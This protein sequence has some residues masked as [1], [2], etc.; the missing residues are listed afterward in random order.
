M[1]IKINI[2]KAMIASS[3]WLLLVP[4]DSEPGVLIYMRKDL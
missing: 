3:D 4:Q 1:K 2:I